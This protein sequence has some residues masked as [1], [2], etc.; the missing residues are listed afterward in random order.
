[1]KLA[2]SMLLLLIVS[3]C[4]GAFGVGDTNK[5]VTV[6]IYEAQKLRFPEYLAELDRIS[7]LANQSSENRQAA[8]EAISHLRGGW[9]VVADKQELEIDTG[10]LIDQFERLKK[11]SDSGIR[12]ELLKRLGD[13]KSEAL[14]FQPEPTDSTAARAT[15]NQI[16]AR[17]EFRQVHGPSWLDRLK[18][19]ILEWISRLLS[20]FFASSS[21]PTA[22]RVLV[23]ALVVLA[24]LVLAFFVYRTIR[25]NAQQESVVPQVAPVSAKGWRTW[26]AEAQAA[27]AQGLWREAVHLAYWAGISF[28]EERSAWR[29]DKARTPREYLRLLPASSEFHLPLSALTR[30]VEVT[31]YGNDPA[32]PET[33]SEIVTL[34][35]NL[36]CRQA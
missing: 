1:M 34:L 2:R 21:V 23:W 5:A 13:L 27:A 10:W 15:L 4:L 9:R 24:V 35:E 20:R 30:K 32:G 18:Y 12:A 26:M 29:P 6:F 17:S 25:R 7:T 11:N 28:L 8:D 31:W 16:L 19:R 33:F 36:G 22:G 14:A 3:L